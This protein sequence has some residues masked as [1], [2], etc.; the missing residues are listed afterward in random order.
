VLEGNGAAL[1]RIAETAVAHSGGRLRIAIS[2]ADD[3]ESLQPAAARFLKLDGK[4][5]GR[6]IELYDF[7]GRTIVGWPVTLAEFLLETLA[8]VKTT[9]P[10]SYH[11][12]GEALKQLGRS[13]YPAD[14]CA[15]W[16]ACF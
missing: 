13:V 2:E 14:A 7:L 3:N 15:E 6:D 10:E 11:H 12:A 9:L 1:L 4:R 5:L 16:D 8:P